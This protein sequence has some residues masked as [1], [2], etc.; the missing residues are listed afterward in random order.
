MKKK[1]LEKEINSN[2]FTKILT[3]FGLTSKTYFKNMIFF[4][5]FYFY[6]LIWIFFIYKGEM[7]TNILNITLWLAL[8]L[9]CY[10]IVCQLYWN[11][12]SKCFPKH[13]ADFLKKGVAG[14]AGIY[15][16]FFLVSLPLLLIYVTYKYIIKK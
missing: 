6:F 4:A 11:F 16:L 3:H 9:I 1:K 10:P 8:N 13:T 5:I 15:I 7:T 14:S 12:I 2:L